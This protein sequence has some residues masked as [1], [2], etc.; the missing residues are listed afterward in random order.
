MLLSVSNKLG[1]KDLQPTNVILQLADRSLT[2]PVG[3]LE[4]VLVKVNK[5][6]IPTYFVVLEMDEDVEIPIILG[7][8]FLA[9]AGAVIDVKHGELTFSIG[10]EQVNLIFLNLANFLLLLIMCVVWIYLLSLL[11]RL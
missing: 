9:T 11:M 6:F 5:F 2:H 1:L 7:R 3:I 4:N 10:D 8:P